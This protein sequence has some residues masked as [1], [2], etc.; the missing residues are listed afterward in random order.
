MSTSSTPWSMRRRITG[1]L[2]LLSAIPVSVAMVIGVF[3]L[4]Q[5]V[6][7]EIEALVR[8]EL[9]E[10]R[11][12]IVS[13]PEPTQTFPAVANEMAHAHPELRMGW[14]L[15][16]TADKQPLG[17]FGTTELLTVLGPSR[18]QFGA[19]HP[20]VVA[21]GNGVYVAD[22]NISNE[23][24]V[25]LVLDGSRQVAKINNYWLFGLGTIG[26]SLL[27]S[28]IA[29]RFLAWRLQSLLDTIA[30]RLRQGSAGDNA[31]TSASEDSTLPNELIPI[32]SE[33]ESMLDNVRQRASEAKLFTAGLAH[34]LRSPLQNLIGEA[35]VAMLRARS[36][37]DYQTLLQRQIS[38]LHEFARSVDNLL[39]L[40]SAN[41]PTRRPPTETFDLAAEVEVRLQAERGMARNHDVQLAVAATGDTTLT[42]DREAIVRAVRNL[43]NNAIKW[44]HAGQTVRLLLRGEAQSLCV[45]V[46]DQGPGIPTGEREQVFTPFAQGSVPNGKRVGFG[47]GLAIIHATAQ[48]HGGSITIDD[49]PDGGALL[50]LVIPR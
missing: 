18:L 22:A 8:E 24:S 33:L 3:Y 46:H 21:L 1:M 43:V 45:E 36:P 28:I 42:A 35:E 23:L 50:R 20:D 34:E 47:L 7:T 26:L 37:E 15:Y 44:S 19:T 5:S 41:E 29:A 38:E 11:S 6:T 49:S 17:D 27:I 13:A 2:V 30:S 4:S 31:S 39:Y 32:A 25:T 16:R 10:A 12:E 48:Q 14:R 40:C 9:E